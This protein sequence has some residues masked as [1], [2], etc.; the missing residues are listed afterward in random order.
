MKVIRNMAH[1]YRIIIISLMLVVLC[2]CQQQ[3]Q[4]QFLPINNWN[5][6]SSEQICAAHVASSD[7]LKTSSMSEC[8]MLCW[9]KLPDCLQLNYYTSPSRSSAYCLLYNYRPKKYYVVPD[10]ENYTCQ[11][12]V[13]KSINYV[14]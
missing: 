13:V 11:H 10:S 14:R 2:Y 8:I 3:D 6:S 4:V 5:C 7:L 1:I 12:Y 9:M